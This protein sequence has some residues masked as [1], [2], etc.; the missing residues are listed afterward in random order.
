[1]KRTDH[2]VVKYGNTAESFDVVHRSIFMNQTHR[3][4]VNHCQF[5]GH[6]LNSSCDELLNEA[7]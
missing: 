5:F 3:Q 2:F 1:M 7:K 4:A 6:V